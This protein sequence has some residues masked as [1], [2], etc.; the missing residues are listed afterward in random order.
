MPTEGF[1]IDGLKGNPPSAKTLTDMGTRC[2]RMPENELLCRKVLERLQ[3]LH[4]SVAALDVKDPS[5]VKYMD[6]IVRFVKLMRRKPLL[7]RL[8]SSETLVTTIRELQL[9]L[10]DVGQAL[11]LADKPEMTKWEVQWDADRAEQYGKLNQLVTGASE[12]M[13]VNEFRGDKKVQ[14]ALMSLNS[15]MKWKGQS[16]EMLE[17]KKK[18]FTR[19]SIYLNQQGLRMFDWFIPID[20]VEYED[21][22]IGDR[23]T[24]GDVSRGTWVHEGERTEVVIKRLFPETSSDS[25]DAFLRQLDLWGGL[26]DNEH[27]LK[28]YGGS[29]VSNPQFY[30]C[31]NAHYGNLAEFLDDE[32]H[33]VLFWRLFHQV[34][35]GL[36]FLHDRKTVHGGLKCNNILVGAKY[37]AKLAD[38][39][40]STVRTLSAGLS[41]NADRANAQSVRWKPKEVLEETGMDETRYKSD[42]YSLAMCMIEAKSHEVP[43]GMDDDPE[44]MDKIMRGERHPCPDGVLDNSTEWAFISQ[45]C[46]PDIDKRP[47]LDEVLEKIGIF[48]DAEEKQSPMADFA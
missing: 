14:E 48:A 36:K 22:A 24:F 28:L 5:K 7:L 39:G 41:G 33:G 3:F 25:D 21:E 23:G 19:V 13:L 32:E 18:T 31:E 12:R 44:A 43:F 9:K 16:P 17:L 47:S 4:D 27:I 1:P 35:L 8:A 6:V 2:R 20:D 10:S 40:F 38:F 34:A 30:V 11:G 45:L 29:H 37:T 46:D 26:P 42:I 15:G